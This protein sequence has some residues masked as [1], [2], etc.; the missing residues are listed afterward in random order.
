VDVVTYHNDIARTGQNLN[1]TVL[2]PANVNAGD[3][4]KIAFLPVDGKVDG[5]PLYLSH[6]RVADRSHNVVFAASE[7]DSV[8]AFDADSGEQ[9]W[10]VSL[11]GAGETPSDDH[12]CSQINPE[13]S[14]TSTPVIDRRRGANGVIYLVAMSKD[15]SGNYHQRLHALDITTGADLFGAPVDIQATY[16]GNGAN[17]FSGEVV[18]D[19]K[20][21]AERVGLLLLNGV[22]YT[23]WTSHCDISPYTGWLIGY[24]AATLTQKGV[25]NLTPNGSEGSIWMSGAGLAADARRNIYFLD[26]NGTFDTTLDADGFPVNGDYGNGF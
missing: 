2:T 6:L 7:H 8:F 24:D 21:Y 12:A 5:Q 9:L 10:R 17:S 23:G 26:A 20:Q 15:G 11:L 14:V 16:R 13:I 1:D 19:P 22:V 4:G 25:L 18:F 3:F